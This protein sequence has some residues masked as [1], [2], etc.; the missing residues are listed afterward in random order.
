MLKTSNSAALK[1]L[2][3]CVLAGAPAH[4]AEPVPFTYAPDH[5]QFSA[6]FPDTPETVKR[7]ETTGDKECYELVSYTHVIDMESS[8]NFKVICNPSGKDLYKAYTED[9]MRTTLR[10]MT[11][12]SVIKTHEISFR[13]EESYKQAGLVGEGQRGLTPT[14]YIAQLW[15]GQTSAMSVEAELVGEP[16]EEADRMF[17]EFLRSVH[18]M[19]PE[20]LEAKKKLE[21]E[22][23]L[24]EKSTEES[25]PEKPAEKNP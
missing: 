6:T 11:D 2:A 20:E 5:C 18:F 14:M 13:E 19:T 24:E 10:A 25:A 8:V 22:E 21:A 3:F 4:A 9:V 7:C 23:T 17:S 1:F 12:R 16:T 15:I